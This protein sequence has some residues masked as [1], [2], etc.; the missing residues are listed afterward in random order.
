M[1]SFSSLSSVGQRR[2][3]AFF[4]TVV[5]V[6]TVLMGYAYAKTDG[7]A[8]AGGAWAKLAEERILFA[9]LFVACGLAA[10]AT[11]FFTSVPRR[12]TL[13]AGAVTAAG[14]AVLV[15][16]GG[17]VDRLTSGLAAADWV[18]MNY[19]LIA[20]AGWGA[21]WAG[22]CAWARLQ[23]PLWGFA[24]LF[25]LAGAAVTVL[26]RSIGGGITLTWLLIFAPSLGYAG[27]RRFPSCP[28][29]V[30]PPS[31]VVASSLGVA[32]LALVGLTLGLVHLAYPIVLFGVLVALSVLLIRPAKL[33]WQSMRRKLLT[34]SRFSLAG[35]MLAGVLG[36]VLV[37]Q[38]IGALAPE[39]GPDAIGARTALSAIWLRH[40]EIFAQPEI[41]L[42]YMS[43]LGESLFLLLMPAAGYGVAKIVA[44]ACLL[45]V[46]SVILKSGSWWLNV[47]AIA[48]AVVFAASTIVWWQLFH[49]FVD[50]LQVLFMLGAAES[51][52]RWLWREDA[53]CLLAAGLL[54]GA[55]T[56][57]KLNGIFVLV[58]VI[59]IPFVVV[60]RRHRDPGASAR[61]ILKVALPALV[62]LGPFALRSAFLTGNPVFPFAN[63]FFK[64]PLAPQIFAVH[65]FGPRF[66][67]GFWRDTYEV[68]LQPGKFAELGTY[69]PLLLPLLAGCAAVAGAC[70]RTAWF[71][72][73]AVLISAGFWLLTEQNLR[74][75]L[76]IGLFA[77]LA[78]ACATATLRRGKGS[79][80]RASSGLLL[81]VAV[82]AGVTL[83]LAR[84]AFWIG[85]IGDATTLPLQW[86]VGRQTTDAFLRLYEPTYPLAV[87]L[88]NT[89]GTRA[90]V[91]ELPHLRDHLYFEG[92][93]VAMPRGD[94][95]MLA[96]L[97][98][99]LPD[100][101]ASL[102]PKMIAAT[103]HTAGITH[104][105]YGDTN[106]WQPGAPE[107]AWSGVYAPA[108][109]S[110][111][112]EPMA[113]SH[114]LRLYRLRASPAFREDSSILL[115]QIPFVTGS[116]GFRVIEGGLYQL[117]LAQTPAMA[118]AGDTMDFAW[119]NDAGRLVLYLHKYLPAGPPGAWHRWLESAPPGSATLDVFLHV[120]QPN[121][122]DAIEVRKLATDN[123]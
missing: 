19:F 2:L 43:T 79:L 21:G 72:I 85:A 28:R 110:A 12:A 46:L 102:S 80:D 114:D 49:G 53:R 41:I 65:D 62:V 84:P 29:S 83:Q 35:A 26:S 78:L 18:R 6:G 93:V 13:I 3:E 116:K 88:N 112:L 104:L 58:A 108:F 10:A 54:A 90:R 117:R 31:A 24:L 37:A 23:P 4:V 42:S 94:M 121:V 5:G 107:S 91:W 98:A 64:S 70:T 47:W 38:W 92:T 1:R 15:V 111:W 52:R 118:A 11:A 97:E 22:A 76:F 87:V 16:I 44:F 7:G 69:H 122:N 36:A 34:P 106:P 57:V 67:P 73:G 61:A 27:W 105:L 101:G 60:L 51:L 86:A 59:V 45:S 82:T 40:G 56:A 81:A 8:W 74:Y 123:K 113:G 50:L 20:G 39:T 109:T 100:R 63:A 99:L 75:T 119:R 30:S 55:A 71:W 48:A 66:G 32:L 33:A 68:F 120:T 9:L 25:I 17:G 115:G 89:A 95:R 96:P 77:I 103:L 14:V